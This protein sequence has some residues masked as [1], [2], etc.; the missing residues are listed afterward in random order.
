[1]PARSNIRKEP[2]SGVHISGPSAFKRRSFS[3]LLRVIVR[4][5]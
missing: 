4:R 2:T 3:A 1:M 5:N